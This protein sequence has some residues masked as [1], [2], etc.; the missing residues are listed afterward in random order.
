MTNFLFNIKKNMTF[1][2]YLLSYIMYFKY[3]YN[4]FFL[5]KKT[6]KNYFHVIKSLKNEKFPIKC[7][8]QNNEISLL[9]KF[10]V[11]MHGHNLLN[12]CEFTD[13]ILTIQI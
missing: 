3:V 10:Q 8:L 5:Y 2:D 13:E 4:G 11:I 6:F 9:N 12:F 7:I 1:G